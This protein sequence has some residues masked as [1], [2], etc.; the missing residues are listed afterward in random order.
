[1]DFKTGLNFYSGPFFVYAIYLIFKL[2]LSLQISHC[3]TFKF[4]N[5]IQFIFQDERYIGKTPKV[6]GLN[7]K[8]VIKKSF[9][10]LS[11]FKDIHL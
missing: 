5:R 1:L 3:K 9:L 11:K 6:F 2:K 7:E 8:G 4:T 10:T